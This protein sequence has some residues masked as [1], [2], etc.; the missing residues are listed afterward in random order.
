MKQFSIFTLAIF[1]FTLNTS[2]QTSCPNV[3]DYDNDGHVAINDFLAMLGF[4]SDSDQDSDG[5]WDSEDDCIDDSAC[6]YLN[7]PT[8]PCYFIDVLGVCGGGC[9]GDSDN[10][11]ICNDIDTCVGI[12]DECCVCNGPG[13]MEIVIESITLLYDSVFLLQLEEWYVY[14]ID[15]DTLMSYVCEPFFGTCGDLVS[16]EGYDY[17]TVQIGEQCWFAETVV[18]SQV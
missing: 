7:N 11:G 10:D 5:V 18:T 4:F 15:A 1:F 6:N 16:H 2:A 13:P 8:E 9:D 17:F 3:F 12:L 14:E